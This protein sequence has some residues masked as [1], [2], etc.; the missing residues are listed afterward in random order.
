M[1]EF[2]NALI[3]RD[4]NGEK[5]R[6]TLKKIG[7]GLEGSL[8]FEDCQYIE[9]NRGVNVLLEDNMEFGCCV[10]SSFS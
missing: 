5:I 8:S 10:N 9:Y 6:K 1:G 3:V 7:S 2:I 4:N